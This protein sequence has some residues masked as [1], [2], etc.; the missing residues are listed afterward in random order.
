[1]IRFILRKA[2][3]LNT[4]TAVK[5]M[6]KIKKTFCNMQMHEMTFPWLY[7]LYIATVYNSRGKYCKVTQNY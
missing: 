1:M 7:D 3:N 2:N 5:Y 6:N 4:Y